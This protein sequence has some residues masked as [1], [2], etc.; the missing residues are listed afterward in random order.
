MNKLKLIGITGIC[1]IVA[2]ISIY[3]QSDRNSDNSPLGKYYR[4][5]RFFGLKEFTTIVQIGKRTIH[6]HKINIRCL[7]ISIILIFF[8]FAFSISYPIF[9]CEVVFIICSRDK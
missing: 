9:L 5:I 4:D 2:F 6:D 1:I 3:A 7:E 8:L